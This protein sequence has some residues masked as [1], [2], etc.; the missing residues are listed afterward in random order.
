MVIV[1]EKMDEKEVRPTGH[2]IS[3]SEPRLNIRPNELTLLEIIF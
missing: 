2:L 3:S 1:A